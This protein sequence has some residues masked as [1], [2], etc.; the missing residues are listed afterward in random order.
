MS[1][2]QMTNIKSVVDTLLKIGIGLLCFFAVQVFMDIRDS[3]DKQGNSI[4]HIKTDMQLVKERLIR[5]ETK[6]ESK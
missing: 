6:I 2:Q 1:T 5:V 3:I 4:D